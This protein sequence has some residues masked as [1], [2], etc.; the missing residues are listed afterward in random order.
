MNLEKQLKEKKELDKLLPFIEKI[1]EE[2]PTAKF[3]PLILGLN[4]TDLKDGN[5]LEI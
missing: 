1:K 3:S 5:L 2:Y 4:E